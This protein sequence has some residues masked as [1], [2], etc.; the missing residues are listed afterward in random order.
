MW[1]STVQFADKC[2]HDNSAT[3]D[4]GAAQTKGLLHPH[5]SGLGTALHQR[6]LS[7]PNICGRSVLCLVGSR[8]FAAVGRRDGRAGSGCGVPARQLAVRCAPRVRREAHLPARRATREDQVS[9]PVSRRDRHDG[10][11][12]YSR[13]GDGPLRI[14]FWLRN[15]PVRHD[16]GRRQREMGGNPVAAM[17][18]RAGARPS[19]N[20]SQ[21]D[22][23]VAPIHPRVTM[24]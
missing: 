16:V 22:D 21:V 1:L 10:E 12:I 3:D 4:R 6:R 2:E 13:V 15:R 20:L 9:I 23:D 19:R 8:C 11:D 18:W 24:C 5:R 17:T 14:R 7:T